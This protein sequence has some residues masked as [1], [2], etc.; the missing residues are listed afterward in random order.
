MKT[1]GMKIKKTWLLCFGLQLQPFQ[2]QGPDHQDPRSTSQRPQP[3]ESILYPR[4]VHH[5][6]ILTMQIICESHGS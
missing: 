4:K 1:K 6:P 3:S 2:D 5:N